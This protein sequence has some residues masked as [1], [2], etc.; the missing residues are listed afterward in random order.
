MSEAIDWFSKHLKLPIFTQADIRSLS[1]NTLT[2]DT[3]QNWANRGL[4]KPVMIHGRRSYDLIETAKLCLTQPL[5]QGFDVGSQRATQMIMDAFLGLAG[6]K[7]RFET[8]SEAH[9]KRLM[10]VYC[11]GTEW[12]TV[13]IVDSKKIYQ[14]FI[15]D[16]GATIIL[17]F[18]RMFL[19]LA[20]RAMALRKICN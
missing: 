14:D 2:I 20:T 4:T 8:I 11:L 18:G 7:P 17:P 9:L 12:P 16:L 5:I 6:F 15:E 3:I 10:A 13:K 1:E 19:D